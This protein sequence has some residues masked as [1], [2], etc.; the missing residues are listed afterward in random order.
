MYMMVYSTA[1]LSPPVSSLSLLRF[2]SPSSLPSP[3][4]I[5]LTLLRSPLPS[6]SLSPCKATSIMALAARHS[7]M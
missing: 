2:H 6:P 3:F 7:I 5:S 1:P 4:L